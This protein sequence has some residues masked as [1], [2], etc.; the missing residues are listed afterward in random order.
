[1]TDKNVLSSLPGGEK[2]T[3]AILVGVVLNGDTA[4]AVD[5]S[6]DEL[7]RLLDTAGGQTYCRVVQNKET[8]DPRTVIGSG[9][10]HEIHD[11]CANAGIDLVIFDI[12]LSPAQIR[13]LEDGIGNDVRVIDRSM[14]ILDIFALHA[15]TG[16]GKLQVELAQ[17]HYTA[18]RLMGHGTEMSRLGGGIGT[19]GPGESKLESDRR[20]LARRIQALESQLEEVQ[21][22]R[23]TMRAARD[24]SG[25][26]RVAVVGYTNAGKST[27]LNYLT[28]AGVLAQDKLFATLD[29]TT[30]Q[31]ELPSGETVLLTDTVGFIRKLPHHLIEAFKS[32]LEEA[33]QADVL[34][35]VIDASDSQWQ[36][37]LQVTLD[38]LTELG[39]GG[40][41]TLYVFNKC[42]L[43]P[44]L[45]AGETLP[46]NDGDR[47]LISAAKGVGVDEL[48]QKLTEK[49]HADKKRIT[50]LIPNDKQNLVHILYRDA[51]VSNVEYLD[52]GVRLTAVVDA[53]TAG[54][55][56]SY[57]VTHAAESEG[58]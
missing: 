14:L 3:Q 48:L 51:E 47:V 55:F 40:K 43:C 28:G 58:Q 6:L 27:L 54:R 36:P 35:L 24:R 22:T 15:T 53:K 29:P 1:M 46:E 11:L 8:P 17:L 56:E 33:A 31:L 5:V 23:R 57:D 7:E 16:E 13:N 12:D 30:R 26:C 4:Q 10:V 37:Q 20:H 41:P 19:R 45:T 18:P 9:K 44:E 25:L 21:K 39:A 2:V 50:Y 52:N 49:I 34:L 42:D 32:T 38:L